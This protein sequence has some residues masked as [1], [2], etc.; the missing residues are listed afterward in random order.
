MSTSLLGSTI[1]KLDAIDSTND[2][3]RNLLLKD[4]NI[5]D[6]TVVITDFQER[7]KGRRTK[8]WISEKGLNLTMSVILYPVSLKVIDQFL[9]TKVVSLGM[10]DYLNSI[11]DDTL[12]DRLRI[13]W[14]NDIYVGGNKI[15]GIL[16]ENIVRINKI[17]VCI[18]GIG[19]NVNQEIFPSEIINPTSIKSELKRSFD[20][21]Q[22]REDL[23]SYLEVRYK[24]LSGLDFELLNQD[25]EDGLLGRG[26]MKNYQIKG[27]RV[28]A[29]LVGVSNFG[30]LV[31]ES[32]DGPRI[33]CDFDQLQYVN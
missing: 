32:Q 19:L 16:I 28:E 10:M 7:G 27:K 30:E 24:Q 11:S 23:C 29:K 31:L 22:V 15:C 6:G 33:V 4:A 17:K 5:A 14:P 21:D 8:T 9:M 3:A 12:S 2:Y 18:V 26:E 1:I 20:L 25:Y 13:K